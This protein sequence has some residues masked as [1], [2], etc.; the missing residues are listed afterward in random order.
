M[1]RF[2]CNECGRGF[3]LEDE[4][5]LYPNVPKSLTCRHCFGIAEQEPEP[6][7]PED[8]DEGPDSRAW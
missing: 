6:D 2:V 4:A 7:D 1:T 3:Y 5:R 8:E